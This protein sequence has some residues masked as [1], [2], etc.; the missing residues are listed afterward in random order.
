MPLFKEGISRNF[1]LTC[2]DTY[3]ILMFM[4]LS[5]FDLSA[6]ATLSLS[7]SLSCCHFDHVFQ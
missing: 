1:N 3:Q 2:H 6:G 4:L 5:L 7:L